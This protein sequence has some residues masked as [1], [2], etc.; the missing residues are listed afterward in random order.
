MYEDKITKNIDTKIPIRN[1]HFTFAFKNFIHS[2][3]DRQRLLTLIGQPFGN[4]FHGECGLFTVKLKEN[5]E[6]TPATHIPV[7]AA[8]HSMIHFVLNKL[9]SNLFNFTENVEIDG[10]GYP[11]KYGHFKKLKNPL[12]ICSDQ[13]YQDIY[14]EKW[15][16]QVET[17]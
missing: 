10:L 4:I 5:H 13:I 8:T 2:E 3:P 6:P 9:R 17:N 1:D 15:N 7:L 16:H 12:C 14:N 11:T